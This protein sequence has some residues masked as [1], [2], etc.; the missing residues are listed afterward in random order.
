MFK[1]PKV[2]ITTALFALVLIV[3]ISI[4]IY[5]FYFTGAWKIL[6][7][8]FKAQVAFSR[9]E[10]LSYELVCHENCM[11]E[12]HRY[13]EAIAD[14][15]ARDP[16]LED[17][18]EMYLNDRGQETN[19]FFKKE[20]V[21]IAKMAEEIKKR[22]DPNYEIKLPDYL[23][24][25]LNRPNVNMDAKRQI[26]ASFDNQI[27]GSSW[28]LDGLLRTIADP[29]K[30]LDERIPAI[31]DLA[32]IAS[33]KDED[34]SPKY[35]NIDYSQVCGILMKLAT[36]KKA[37]DML[38]KAALSKMYACTVFPENYSKA[39]FEKI[40]EVFEDRD[41]HLGIR[42]AALD[43]IRFYNNVSSS[44]VISYMD[45]VY[46]DKDEHPYLR[47][48]AYG[49]FKDLGYEEYKSPDVTLEE[50]S[51]YVNEIGEIWFIRQD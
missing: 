25:Y 22:Q 8:P 13:K 48:G 49:F 50:A 35:E 43:E 4:S 33:E 10:I 9:L 7:Q 1:K 26:M 11:L 51:D 15:L 34:G 5:L 28:V 14:Q 12:A 21:K 45:K 40:K 31:W 16:V 18:F 6:P 47:L 17:Q 19:S 3:I 23:L 24:D 41:E 36:D 44:T 27:G 30:S 20:L 29:A 46:N 32:N 42:D 39:M 37:D 2:L 38:R